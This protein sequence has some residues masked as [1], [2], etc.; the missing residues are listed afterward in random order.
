MTTETLYA[1]RLLA[2]EVLD[3]LK[4]GLK[5]LNL[6][7]AARRVDRESLFGNCKGLAEVGGGFA[8]RLGTLGF[9]V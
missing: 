3:D 5:F 9:E 6:D 2:S 4:C 7:A 8:S 1:G